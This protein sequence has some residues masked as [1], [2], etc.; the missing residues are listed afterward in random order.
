MTHN[1]VYM[2]PPAFYLDRLQL[3]VSMEATSSESEDA[4]ALMDGINFDGK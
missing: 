2:Y 3:V 1:S 4:E